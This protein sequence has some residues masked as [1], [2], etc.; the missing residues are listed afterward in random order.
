M[1]VLELTMLRVKVT[2]PAFGIIA[3]VVALLC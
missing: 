1:N 3:L 2:L